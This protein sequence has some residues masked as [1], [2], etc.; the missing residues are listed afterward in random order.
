M[1]QNSKFE[2]ELP[3]LTQFKLEWTPF[4]GRGLL[5]SLA[6]NWWMLLIRGIAA[7][8]FGILAFLWPVL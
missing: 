4:V 6:D 2:G 7:I 3:W 8:A 1:Q 5:S